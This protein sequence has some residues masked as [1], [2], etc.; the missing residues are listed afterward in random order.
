MSADR[1]S[2]GRSKALIAKKESDPKG[3]KSRFT[4]GKGKRRCF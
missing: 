2:N 1:N 4:S 3:L